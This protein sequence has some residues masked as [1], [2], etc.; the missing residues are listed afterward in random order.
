MLFY[1]NAEI[2][3]FFSVFPNISVF[4]TYETFIYYRQPNQD[5]LFMFLSYYI[6]NLFCQN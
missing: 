5:S 2:I 6:Q 3:G 1:Q 4:F